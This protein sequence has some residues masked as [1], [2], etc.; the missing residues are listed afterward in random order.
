VSA[1]VALGLSIRDVVTPGFYPSDILGWIL[2]ALSA[3][4]SRACRER[5]NAMPTIRRCGRAGPF[6]GIEVG[7]N[8]AGMLHQGKRQA[9]RW[10]SVERRAP[11]PCRN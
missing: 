7:L 6:S 8:E 9:R 2:L 11:E 1:A 10:H 4:S 5:M 3:L